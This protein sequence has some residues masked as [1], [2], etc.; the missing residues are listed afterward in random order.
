MVIDSIFGMPLQFVLTQLSDKN[1]AQF[2]AGKLGLE[3]LR[4]NCVYKNYTPT[5]I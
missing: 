1:E 4:T 2:V 5:A 3:V